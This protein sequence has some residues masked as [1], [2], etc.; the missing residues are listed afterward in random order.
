MPQRHALK[1]AIFGPVCFFIALVCFFAAGSSG[2]FAATAFTREEI[3]LIAREAKG[4]GWSARQIEA[5]FKNNKVKKMNDLVEVNVTQPIK[6]SHE[7]YKHY[8]H[9]DSVDK[10]QEFSRKWRTQLAKASKRYKVDS[11]VIVGILLVETN[12]GLYKGDHPLISVFSSVFVDTR[13]LLNSG[14][15]K[16]NAAMRKRLAKKGAWALQEFKALLQM[17][18]RYDF[19]L[20]KLKGSY[21]GAF[22]LPQFLPSSYVKWAVS[23]NTRGKRPNL[24]WEPDAIHS[25]A[26]YLKAHGYRIGAAKRQRK[27]AVWFYN[28]SDVYVDT[29]FG[30]AH[31]VKKRE[32]LASRD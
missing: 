28:N 21:A 4:Q 25:V 27:R 9:A 24:Y 3:R 31:Y 6:L 16:G 13:R 12:L 23:S 17:K 5:L 10:A 11:E 32:T 19:D 15:F 7:R 1:G 22:G 18:R 29:V 2:A 30:V 8:T 26:N 14:E 20:Y